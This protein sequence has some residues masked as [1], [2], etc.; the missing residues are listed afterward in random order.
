MKIAFVTFEYPPDTAYGGIAAYMAH[1]ARVLHSRGHTIEVFTASPH[2]SGSEQ[3]AGVTVHRVRESVPLRFGEAI[4]PVFAAR[5]RE[6]GFDV[7]EGPEYHADARGA[8][9]EVPDIPLV[10]TLHT[11]SSHLLK[12]N[13]YEPSTVRRVRSYLGVLAHGSRP[14]WGYP[15]E[16]EGYREYVSRVA[17]IERA[18]ARDADEIV[19]PS[20]A[21]GARLIAEWRLDPHRV[22]TI[23]FSFQPSDALLRI[24]ADTRTNVITFLGRL[25]RR[26]GVLDLARA[27]PHIL[28]RFPGARFRF[29]GGAEGSPVP[30]VDMRTYLEREL[31]AHSESVEFTGQVPRERIPD[32]L[33]STDI[34]VLPSLW[35]N[36]PFAC[37]EAMTA[38]RGVV[39]SN[40]GGMADMLDGGCAGR[41]VPP[42]NPGALARAV[43]ELLTNPEERIALGR[44]ARERVATVYGGDRLGA[45]REASFAR[46][47]A[48]RQ[49]A[50]PRT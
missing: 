49:A 37:L 25:E 28:A 27:I 9:R 26:K 11:P 31:S 1:A 42:R 22:V 48:R 18:H 23:P 34:V 40:A 10:I 15:P 4:A 8:V 21:L 43:L 12:L 17:P 33:T 24:P 41:L 36:F 13:A 46:A 30:S 39:A 6:V 16:Q 2:R 7:L 5:H 14:H 29:I 32:V 44:A 19:S 3:E 45:R 50:G 35:E 38:A 20:R 47:I